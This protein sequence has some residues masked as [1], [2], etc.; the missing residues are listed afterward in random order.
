MDE[1]NLKPSVSGKAASLTADAEQ[2]Q[3]DPGLRQM[4]EDHDKELEEV[5]G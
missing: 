2:M 4:E 5:Q 1:D 3:E